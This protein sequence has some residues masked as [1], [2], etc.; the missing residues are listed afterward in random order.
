MSTRL[1]RLRA[2]SNAIRQIAA[3][4]K[5]SSIAVFGSVARGEDTENTDYDFLVAF[6]KNSSL[7]DLAALINELEDFLGSHV[8]VVSIG[9]LKPRDH[10]IREEA[11]P[12]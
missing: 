10:R 8:Y 1:E 6:E 12:L 4:H 5:A 11:I 7:L 3:R 9:G 2:N